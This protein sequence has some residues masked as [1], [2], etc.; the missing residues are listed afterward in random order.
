[1]MERKKSE[2]LVI[3][4][5]GMAMSYFIYLAVMRELPQPYADYNGHTYVYLSVFTGES[6]LKGW[7]TIPYCMWHMCVLALNLLLHVPLEASAA[8]V[9]CFF[10]VFTYFIIYWMIRK[11][12]K[13]QGSMMGSSGAAAI[14]AGLSIVQALYFE[15]LDAGGRFLG[16]F[17]INPI[18]NPTQMA[19]RP[20]ILLSFALVIDIWGVQRDKGY[21]GIF[22]QVENGLKRYYLYLAVVLLLSSM[23]KPVFAAMFIPAVGLLMLWE[24]FCSILRKDG[25]AAAYFKKCLLMLLCAAPTVLYIL[26]QF[27]SYYIWGETYASS[28]FILTK[29]ME[30]WNMFSENVILSIALGMA[31]PL[32]MILID[33]RFFIK[34]DMGRLA[35]AGY[36]I[37]VLEAAVM[38]EGGGKMGQGDYIWPMTCGMLLLWITALLRLVALAGTQTDTKLKRLLVAFAWFLFCAHVLCGALLLREMIGG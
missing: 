33:G 15:W 34:G 19:V 17:S 11:Y 25:S 16:T 21:K 2:D 22:F 12:T 3:I 36:F 32:F 14:A 37:G 5:L 7:R 23:A 26:L 9:S 27:L 8:Y 38:G 10:Q 20:F 30:V 1:M 31:F 29:W 24:W 4:S 35:L 28:S 18:H 6:W 13:A